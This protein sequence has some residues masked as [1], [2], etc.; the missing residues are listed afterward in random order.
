M[1]ADFKYYETFSS[2]S[3]R[4]I[5]RESIFGQKYSNK[6]FLVPNL[7]IFV[8]SQNFAIRKIRRS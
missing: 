1:G 4:K 5:P 8:S 6:V 2:N 3:R 7:S